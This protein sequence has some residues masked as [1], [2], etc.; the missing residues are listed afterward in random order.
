MIAVAP[1]GM[2]L[3]KRMTGIPVLVDVDLRLKIMDRYEGY[4]Q[5]LTLAAPPI[6]AVGGPD[7]TPDLA[8]LA[9]DEMAAL[10]DRYPD[11]FP[12]FVA[13]LP[14]NN[15]DAAVMEID[16]AIDQLHATGVQI[17]TNVAGRPLD[18]PE[19]QPIFDRMAA[20]DLPIWMHPARP[21]QVA[22][23]AGEKRSKYDLWWAFGWPYETSIAMGRLVFS[24]IFDRHPNLKIITHHLGAMIPFC[25]GRIGGGLDQLGS[26]TD[27]PDDNA[28]LKRL[29]KRPIDYFKM[30]YNDTA[31]FGAWSAMESGLA[32]FGAERVLFGTD[33]PFDPEQGPGFIRDTIAAMER[34]RATPEE[35][36]TIYEGNAR[37]LLR[38]RLR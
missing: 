35:K 16:R 18:L 3:Q 7:V 13:S 32:F 1:P 6:E 38:L 24:G 28:A 9:N 15:P 29:K 26:R 36:Q 23:Y 33:M 4:V 12:G 37:R 30:F 14:M 10:V 22:D 17:F 5:V 20:R 34:M 25:A 19:Y 21:P 11:R 2:A 27:D 31:L 8:R